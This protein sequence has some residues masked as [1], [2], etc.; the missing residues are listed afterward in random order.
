M[1]LICTGCLSC[2]CWGAPGF[3]LSLVTFI[4]ERILLFAAGA[5][6]SPSASWA[7]A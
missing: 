1:C 5:L 2:T 3:W 7:V 4:T 6:S